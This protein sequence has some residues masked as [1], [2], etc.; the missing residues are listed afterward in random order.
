MVFLKLFIII[1][2]KNGK[3]KPFDFII[4]THVLEHLSNPMKFLKQLKKILK[5]WKAYNRGA[6]HNE[7]LYR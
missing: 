6:K 7:T 5:K 2:K 3:K 4:F 1:K